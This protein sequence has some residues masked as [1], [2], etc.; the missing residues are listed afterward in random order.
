MLST[1]LLLLLIWKWLL[2]NA[3]TTAS[4]IM[5]EASARL[6]VA[7]C[8]SSLSSSGAAV[9]SCFRHLLIGYIRPTEHASDWS[10][11]GWM[12]D[13]P[14]LKS[15]PYSCLSRLP[16]SIKKWQFSI[17]IKPFS[18]FF[19]FHKSIRKKVVLF[20]HKTLG[21]ILRVAQQVEWFFKLISTILTLPDHH[22]H[23]FT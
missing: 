18:F 5:S 1:F 3:T 7:S 10:M 19:V 23:P 13:I 15:Q 8:I 4:T 9:A 12:C 6:P 11:A 20:F 17:Y 22:F 14:I 2:K 21:F 16:A